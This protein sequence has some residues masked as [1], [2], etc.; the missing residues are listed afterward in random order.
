MVGKRKRFGAEILE[1]SK[2]TIDLKNSQ[3]SFKKVEEIKREIS[4]SQKKRNIKWKKIRKIMLWLLFLNFILL[5]MIL[6]IGTIIP[7]PVAFI[8]IFWIFSFILSFVFLCIFSSIRLGYTDKIE[9]GILRML[10][11]DYRK[12]MEYF[13]EALK[14]NNRKINAW[15]GLGYIY[16]TA[17]EYK[18]AIY[19]CKM[20]L[21]I[22]PNDSILWAILSLVY[23]AINHEQKAEETMKKL[24]ELGFDANTS[25]EIHSSYPYFY[26]NRSGV[27]ERYI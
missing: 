8:R 15:R 2:I 11:F 17:N 1:G 22:D 20:G 26:L 16:Y 18:E 4:S 13:I 25:F 19:A 24:V 9:S 27:N 3:V 14:R 5:V 21:E 6:F 12:A 7:F 23:Q 10:F